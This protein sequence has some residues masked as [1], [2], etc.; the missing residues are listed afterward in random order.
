TGA[1]VAAPTFSL[2]EAIGGRRNWDYRFTWVRDTSFT[3]Y[4]LIRL[5]LVDEA[6]A[7]MGFMERCFA[8][9]NP[10]GSLQIMYGLRGEKELTE[11]ELPHLSGYRCSKPV[12]IGNGA[13]D[14]LQLDIYGELLDA[15][16]L[17][18]KFGP[19]ISYDMWCSLRKLVNYV[20]DHWNT[21]DM[22]IWEVRS[23]EQHF[24]YSKVMCWVAV[25]RGLRL[26]EKR[27]L[28]CPDRDRWFKV[29]DEIYEQIQER[30]YNKELKCFVQSFESFDVLDAAVLIMPLVFFCSPTDPRL[31]NTIE[32]VLLP[33]E[34]GGLT[35][36]NLVYRCAPCRL[37]VCMWHG[38]FTMC[39][40]WLI[41]ALTRAGNYRRDLLMRALVMFQ[42]ML[43]YGNHLS[44]FS[45]EIAQGGELLGNFPQA[46]SHIAV[47][48]TAFNL[49]R[50]L[51][52]KRL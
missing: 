7:Y 32:R 28:P 13:Y 23:Q 30:A 52:Q 48:S 14:H 20:C 25:D 10:D 15:A 4:A 45:E 36:N 38:S 6:E 1:V 19:P 49:D 37:T 43:D 39:C 47:I 46:F 8:S 44:L 34:K 21:P 42:Q 41:E 24:T 26:S 31:L 22:S 11:Q 5:G 9:A 27:V 33:P 29:R 50:A 12:R 51:R 40:F 2:P 18:N 16:Y 35:A 3:V 17:F